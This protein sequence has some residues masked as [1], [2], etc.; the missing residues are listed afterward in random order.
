MSRAPHTRCARRA[1]RPLGAVALVALLA[2]GAAGAARCVAAAPLDALGG[3]EADNRDQGYG[4]AG[5]G[6][7]LPARG[8]WGV[9]V[10]ATASYLYYAYDSTGSTIRVHAPGVSLMGGVRLTG[11]RGSVS[12]LAGGEL[13][14]ER[15]ATGPEPAPARHRITSGGVA[16]MDGEL[17]LS[18]RWR[19]TALASYGAAARYWYGRGSLRCQLDNLDWSGPYVFAVGPEAV[20]QGNDESDGAQAGV[21]GSCSLV[22]LQL[23]LDLHAGYRESGSPGTRHLRGGY[24]GAGVYH[25]F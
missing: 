15:R 20:R 11:P 18:R 8:P 6:L 17:A 25:H 2:L 9:P 16:Q 24:L 3:W 14:W 19:A 12:L 5:V 7:M 1:R 21:F 4:Y 13:R 22:R 10:R 23:S